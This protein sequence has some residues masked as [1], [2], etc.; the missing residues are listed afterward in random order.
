MAVRAYV[1]PQ[2][3]SPL[4]SAQGCIID[5]NHRAS[6]NYV[7]TLHICT[8]TQVSLI[9]LIPMTKWQTTGTSVSTCYDRCSNSD[10]TC[11]SMSEVECWLSEH[12]AICTLSV[13]NDA[14][15]PGYRTSGTSLDQYTADVI[16]F[17]AQ[18]VHGVLV[19]HELSQC[20]CDQFVRWSIPQCLG[21]TRFELLDY[22][23]LPSVPGPHT[24]PPPWPCY[25]QTDKHPAR[26]DLND[27]QQIVPGHD[28]VKE[29]AQP[30]CSHSITSID[31]STGL[32]A[33]AIIV[34]TALVRA[35]QRV[36]EGPSAKD[37]AQDDAW[38]N[39][40]EG[41]TRRHRLNSLMCSTE[42]IHC[43]SGVKQ[44]NAGY[45]Y[46]CSL[47][48]HADGLA[49]RLH[50]SG[51]WARMSLCESSGH[52]SELAVKEH[53]SLSV[54]SQPVSKQQDS[55]ATFST[56][57]KMSADSPQKLE[58]HPS[59]HNARQSV[60]IRSITLVGF[61][62][63]FGRI[64]AVCRGSGM[65]ELHTC[66]ARSCSTFQTLMCNGTGCCSCAQGCPCVEVC[67]SMGQAPAGGILI[68]YRHSSAQVNRA[69]DALKAASNQ[70]QHNGPQLG[71]SV[72]RTRSGSG[73]GYLATSKTEGDL[74]LY[75]GI[76]QAGERNGTDASQ[77]YTKMVT[78][79]AS[80][81]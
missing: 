12:H 52:P 43:D 63:P 74:N 81:V 8:G 3:K 69:H 30:C 65:S 49:Q 78:H 58:E 67:T 10:C 1:L 11:G 62:G 15:V 42:L 35:D 72:Q 64:P 47:C 13:A 46:A 53:T 4:S 27:C 45:H 50:T 36:K 5:A 60:A 14:I 17:A 28:S 22:C 54:L 73:T 40:G 75:R 70:H 56:Q 33:S 61:V 37:N 7:T 66:T 6:G 26:Q 76:M 19:G 16:Q 39:S 2:D 48:R 9:P 23:V 68:G 38:S 21:H 80:Q 34:V 55:A 59:I 57:R 79:P 18:P 71:S 41:Q 29:Q 77:S 31:A 25:T 44:E 20:D 51:L 32:P 24:L